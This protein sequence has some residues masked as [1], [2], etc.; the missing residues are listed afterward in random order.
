MAGRPTAAAGLPEALLA[1]L[2]AVAAGL[3]PRPPRQDLLSGVHNPFGQHALV[4]HAWKF[5]DLAESAALLD[6]IEAAIGPDIV[7]W[8]SELHLSAWTPDPGEGRWWPVDPPAGAIAGVSLETGAVVIADIRRAGGA[9]AAGRGGAALV[10]RYMP[11]SSRFNRDP[12]FP[13]N[14]LAAEARPLVNYARRPLWLVRGEDRAG[15]DFVTGFMTPAARW[16]DAVWLLPGSGAGKRRDTEGG[17]RC[18]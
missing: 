11:S 18:R 4:S 15:N 7:L 10:L 1:P 14:R 13:P 2:R 6:R 8:D 9:A 12:R 3:A 5:L 17:G 16:T